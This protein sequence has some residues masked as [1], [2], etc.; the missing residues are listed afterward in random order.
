M[1]KFYRTRDCPTCG[2]LED[3]NIVNRVIV[4]GDNREGAEELPEGTRLPALVD[5]RQVIEG[6]EAIV[7]HLEELG[8][9]KELW[10]K[11]QSDSCYC[12]EEGHV[13]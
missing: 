13:L 4:V 7:K 3:L 12:D 8:E 1:L 2:R 5:E 6:A 9:F 11:F 10:C